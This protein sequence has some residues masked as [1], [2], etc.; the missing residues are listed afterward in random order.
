LQAEPGIRCV[1]QRELGNEDKKARGVSASWV[2]FHPGERSAVISSEPSALVP[3][4]LL[5]NALSRSSASQRVGYERA[6]LVEM[7]EMTAFIRCQAEPG[8]W[9]V[10]KRELGNEDERELGNEDRACHREL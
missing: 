2:M 3:K 6:L 9:C 10:P 7:G 5:G 8:I 4:L 1:P